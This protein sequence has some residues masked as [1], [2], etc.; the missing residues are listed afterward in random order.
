MWSKFAKK[1]WQSD[2]KRWAP[3]HYSAEALYWKNATAQWRLP[4][5]EEKEEAM[6][7]PVGYTA[8]SAETGCMVSQHDRRTQLGNGMCVPQAMRI[9]EDLPPTEAAGGLVG[10]LNTPPHAPEALSPELQRGTL[11]VP[12]QPSASVGQGF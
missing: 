8:V 1:R 5:D 6:G 10:E 3:Y 11:G 2:G 12:A 4:S 7:L 9:L